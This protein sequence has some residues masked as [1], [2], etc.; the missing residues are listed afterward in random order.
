MVEQAKSEAYW[1]ELPGST[2]YSFTITQLLSPVLAPREFD[3]RAGLD[4]VHTYLR[5]F[6]DLHLR[7][8][9]TLPSEPVAG[10]ADVRWLTNA[11]LY[12]FPK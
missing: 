6:F 1:L 8:G 12:P 5:T 9:Q 11:R 2:H 7:N 10:E 4:T 3:P